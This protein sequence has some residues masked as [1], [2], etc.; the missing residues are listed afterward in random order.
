[1]GDPSV[2]GG[3]KEHGPSRGGMGGGHR[4]D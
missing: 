2:D 3:Q 4:L 1:L